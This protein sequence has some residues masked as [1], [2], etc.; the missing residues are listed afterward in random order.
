MS[1]VLIIQLLQWR[2]RLAWACQPHRPQ[3]TTQTSQCASFAKKQTEELHV[4]KPTA[5]F[6][7]LEFTRDRTMFGDGHYPEVSKRIGKLTGQGP[8]TRTIL[9][10]VGW[11]AGS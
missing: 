6:K 1:I 7:V 4:E 5:H 8:I 10:F 3:D 11:A 2:V 9:K